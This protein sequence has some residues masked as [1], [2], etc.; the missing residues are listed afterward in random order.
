MGYLTFSFV[1]VLLRTCR[2]VRAAIFVNVVIVLNFA[3][4]Y[5]KNVSNQTFAFKTIT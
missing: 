2:L 5:S 3:A 1:T 4:I